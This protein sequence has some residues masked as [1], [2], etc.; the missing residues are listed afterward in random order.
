MNNYI[1]AKNLTYSVMSEK[2]YL[3]HI[4]RTFSQHLNCYRTELDQM[5]KSEV[6]VLDNII[7]YVFSQGGKQIRPLLVLLSASML[8]QPNQFTYRS[9]ALIEIL[10]NATLLHDDVVDE[11]E[12]RRGMFS[13][14]KIWKNKIAILAGDYFLA[15][16]LSVALQYGYYD[17]LHMISDATRKMSESE[18]W[19]LHHSREFKITEQ[20]YFRIIEAKT[21]VLFALCCKVGALTVEASESDQQLFYQIGLAIGMLF[22]ISD[23]IMD[24]LSTQLKK[25]NFSDIKGKN[26]TLPVIHAFC[27][28]SIVEKIRMTEIIKGF[29]D[30]AKQKTE[31]LHWLHEKGSFEYAR[32]FM[33]QY[34]DKALTLLNEFQNSEIKQYFKDIIRYLMLRN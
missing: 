22:Q 7:K 25:N 8:G 32:K 5:L 19:Q 31:I 21:A 6:W 30:N 18:L 33:S 10:H 3:S 20:E 14:N 29:N 23:D 4:Y 12:Q 1:F 15:T 13:V 9:A 16:G 28:S 26:L 17:L 34:A 24:F 2:S 27:N 11:A